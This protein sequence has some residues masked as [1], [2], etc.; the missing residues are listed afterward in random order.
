MKNI[1]LNN[2]CFKFFLYFF[3][4]EI[5]GL[6]FCND[7]GFHDPFSG[8]GRIYVLTTD[9]VGN[10]FAAGKRIVDSITSLIDN[11]QYSVYMA[12][13]N[14]DNRPIFDALIK[15]K[16]RGLIVKIVGDYHELETDGYK[17]LSDAGINL[18]A[19]NLNAIQH[20]KF[21]IVDDK[22]LVTGTGNISH[23]DFYNNDNHFLIIRDEAIAGIYKKEFQQMHTGFFSTMKSSFQ[24][25]PDR[26]Q[27][28]LPVDVYFSPQESRIGVRHMIEKINAATDSIYYM[29]YAFSHDEIAT[30]LI[31][32]SRRGVRVYGIHDSSFIKGTSEEAPRL[33]MSGFTS[34]GGQYTTGPFVRAD[35]NT[36]TFY[37][38]G[39]EHGGKMHCKTMIIDPDTDHGVVL[40][41][42]FNWSNNAVENNDENL[43]SIS[44]TGV[45]RAIKRQWDQA[46]KISRSLDNTFS[47]ISGSGAN[48]GDVY[49]SEINWA[50]TSNG[51]AQLQDD[52]YVEIFNNSSKP[53]DLTHWTLTWSSH[54]TSGQNQTNSDFVSY[55]FPDKNDGTPVKNAV[56]LP[57]EYRILY[58]SNSGIISTAAAYMKNG[59]KIPD[60]KKFS[61]PDADFTVALYDKD[62]NLID[63]ADADYRLREGY[64]DPFLKTVSS[65]NRRVKPDGQPD[66]GWYSSKVECLWPVCQTPYLYASPGYKNEP[67]G[68]TTFK[69]VE[70]NSD[71]SFTL[72]FSGSVNFCTN[73]A[74]YTAY[75]NGGNVPVENITSQGESNRL[76]FQING[77]NDN[78]Q[79]YGLRSR[80]FGEYEATSLLYAALNIFMGTN[81]G[82]SVS[83]DNGATFQK[84]FVNGN[85]RLK[86]YKITYD[87]ATFKMY[88][89]TNNGFFSSSDNG[90][91]F[92]K[93][94]I[95]ATP[96]SNI[97]YDVRVNSSYLVAATGDG[98]YLANKSLLNFQKISN[99]MI[100]SLYFTDALL[101]AGGDSAIYRFV[102]PFTTASAIIGVNGNVHDIKFIGGTFF[103]ATS[104]GLYS[105]SDGVNFSPAYAGIFSNKAL[106]FIDHDTLNNP[107]VLSHDQISAI[108]PAGVQT[109]DILINQ[110]SANVS[111]LTLNGSTF[112]TAGDY[113]LMT[114]N[115]FDMLSASN[116][117]SCGAGQFLPAGS[118]V[119]NGYGQAADREP[120]KLLLNEMSLVNADNHDWIE[121]Y[122][123]GSG[124]LK[125]TDVEYYEALDKNIIYSFPDMHVNAQDV[126][127][128]YLES[129]QDQKGALSN[130]ATF[131]RSSPYVFYSSRPNLNRGDGLFIVSRNDGT[132][133]KISDVLYYTNRDGHVSSE[134]MDGGLQ[135]AYFNASL[136]SMF[137]NP[138]PFPVSG[139]NDIVIQNSGVKI[140]DSG[141]SRA[142]VRTSFNQNLWA[143]QPNP[144]PGI[145]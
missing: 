78:A 133:E 32:A 105:S 144:T 116:L 109:V 96:L 87:A 75:N 76:H 140:S 2:I 123:A 134:F 45:V 143:T 31:Q 18:V 111:S 21:I 65:I 136:Q 10:S 44:N 131:A 99:V 66:T 57:G 120:A 98:L 15:A 6:C 145:K 48:T 39:I 112:L 54:K 72:I 58:G 117:Y 52:D 118:I 132:S 103:I 17:A 11:A 110:S 36:N 7:P 77:A 94:Q 4:F 59:I 23:S 56:I 73:P 9:P 50:G 81:S 108:Y 128:I 82:L 130:D 62:M 80:V 35:G 26:P 102:S 34:F 86:T 90:L 135:K 55:S 30:A 37:I 41:G 89:A 100:F 79:T 138:L 49:I 115:T 27:T 113:G 122:V 42:S 67:V 142:I 33:Y 12:V 8:R 68:P 121:L 3:I 125:N 119:F 63:R 46:W 61:L 114:G 92:Q 107:L 91:T 106:N 22:I 64:Y 139:W 5:A 19:G 97:V 38:N 16:K 40:T 104:S 85:E 47:K 53:I 74:D 93:I 28:K 14:F 84:L 95:A 25:S 24:M 137:T 124:T 126:I 60:S 69:A 71:Q 101:L 13:Y 51:A 129:A 141:S 88:V 83:S 29:I 70:T 43:L 20:D 127:M 1:R